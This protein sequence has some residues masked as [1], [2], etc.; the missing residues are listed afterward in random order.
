MS[1]GSQQRRLSV[2]VVLAEIHF[3][4][5]EPTMANYCDFE[6][7]CHGEPET[8]DRF[9]HYVLDSIEQD[10]GNQRH[11]V[12]VPL[13]DGTFG[14]FDENKDVP[15]LWLSKGNEIERTKTGDIRI[16]GWCNWEVPITWLE[17]VSNLMPGIS[18]SVNATIE[19]ELYQTW[20]V[21][22]GQSDMTYEEFIPVR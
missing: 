12:Y 18:F 20:R 3:F 6:I 17:Q 16:V 15:R 5:E 13:D 8:L 9:A 19:Y 4:L 2:R 14:D 7:V 21:A 10:P 22:D 1:K 11:E